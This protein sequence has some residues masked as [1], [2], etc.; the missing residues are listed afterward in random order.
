VITNS[1]SSF[2]RAQYVL[3]TPDG[4]ELVLYHVDGETRAPVLIWGHANSFAAGSYRELFGQLSPHCSVWAWD[5]RGQGASTLP[6]NAPSSATIT[7]DALAAD[8]EMV[9]AYVRTQTGQ[10]PHVAAHSFSGSA[11]LWAAKRGLEWRSATFFEPPLVTPERAAAEA[12]KERNQRSVQIALARRSIWDSPS[13]F[14]ARLR[15]LPAYAQ[16]SDIVLSAHVE[17]GLKRNSF[18]RWELC[19]APE[20]E[21]AVYSTVFNASV[22][23]SLSKLDLPVQF[24]ASDSVIGSSPVQAV[25]ASAGAVIRRPAIYLEGTSH[26]LPLERPAECAAVIL[27]MMNEFDA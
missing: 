17:A 6:G 12:A 14:L 22:F 20:T 23:T 3:R 26:L 13:M 5:S 25:Q 9:C 18:G 16:I 4:A 15:A 21:A 1:I 27:K 2:A 19:C 11:L 24:V 8:A 10:V 7:L